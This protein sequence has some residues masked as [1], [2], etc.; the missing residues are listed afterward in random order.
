MSSPFRHLVPLAL[1]L[2]CSPASPALADT[3]SFPVSGFDKVALRG[4]MDVSVRTGAA[5]EVVATGD[6]AA[7]DRL[8]IRVDGSELVIAMKSGS[9]LG[10]S[11]DVAV[12][13]PKLDGARIS[14][15]GDM[16]VERAE[17]ES[18][19][20]AVSGSGDMTLQNFKGGNL[21]VALSGSGD[22]LVSGSC[23]ALKVALS[24]SGDVNAGRL[25]CKNAD[26]AVRGSG[27]VLANAAHTANVAVV[28]SG[29]VNVTGKARCTVSKTGSGEVRCGQP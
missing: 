7:L 17:A 5:F 1:A 24:G 28:G 21:A 19:V 27:N 13:L 12:T 25:A 29:S 4:S 10:S 9:W 11:P 26:I 18:F 16:V 15:S 6:K 20:L 2:L 22:I 8:D 14:G 3:R 23:M